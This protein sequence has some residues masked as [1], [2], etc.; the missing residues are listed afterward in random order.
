MAE[1]V[2]VVALVKIAALFAM[3]VTASAGRSRSFGC[4]NNA[5]PVRFWPFDYARFRRCV[6]RLRPRFAGAILRWPGVLGWV[7][8][9]VSISTSSHKL[10]RRSSKIVRNEIWLRLSHWYGYGYGLHQVG[11]MMAARHQT[12]YS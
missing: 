7:D 4:G 6:C 3:S 12:I 1:D 10:Y 11:I 8:A 2:G 5:G 9:V